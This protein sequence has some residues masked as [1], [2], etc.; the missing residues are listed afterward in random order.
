MTVVF[1]RE[2]EE[3]YRLS[4][5]STR[6]RFMAL[7]FVTRVCNRELTVLCQFIWVHSRFSVRF[8]C[9]RPHGHAVPTY[10][11]AEHLTN[12]TQYVQAVRKREAV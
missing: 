10:G 6:P 8:V 4:G 5:L 12:Y 11:G 3:E 9:L 1:H 7:R 2:P